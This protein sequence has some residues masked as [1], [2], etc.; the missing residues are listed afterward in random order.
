MERVGNGESTDDE[1][2][3]NPY[4]TEGYML[5]R[6][7]RASVRLTAQHLLW[8]DQLGFLLHPDIPTK[9]VDLKIADIGTGNGIWL[10]D[11]AT[12][13]HTP[14]ELHGFDISFDQLGPKQWLPANIR[15]HILDVFEEPPVEFQ[16]FFDIVHVRLIS[17]AVRDNDP[18]PILAH[19]T[20][21]LKPGGYI[22]WDEVDTVGSSIKTVPG[23]S[24]KNLAALYKQLQGR[25]N[26]KY[27]LVQ[28]MNENGYSNTSLHVYENNL[29]MARIWSDLYVTTWKEF[30]EY[31]IK[32]PEASAQLELKAMEE[33]R[34]GAAIHIP[35][36]V[37]VARKTQ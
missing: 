5:M 3:V 11:F 10:N 1:N 25:D 2:Y 33:S 9:G 18:R 30:S 8:K 32:T 4:G 21:L 17:P 14:C 29:G 35:K 34:N 37:W 36:L 7:S 15:M 13:I 24:A 6:D 12:K 22:Q 31:H 27:D 20:K 23:V 26:W 28:I 19:M 16:A